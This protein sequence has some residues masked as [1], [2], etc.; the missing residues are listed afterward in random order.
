LLLKKILPIFQISPFTNSYVEIS[1][2]WIFQ[3]LRPEC[4]R[5]YGIA[6]L[7]LAKTSLQRI[8]FTLNLKYSSAPPS[9]HPGNIVPDMISAGWPVEIARRVYGMDQEISDPF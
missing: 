3:V 5:F 6:A 8:P 4:S 7:S 9:Q 1:C 2:T